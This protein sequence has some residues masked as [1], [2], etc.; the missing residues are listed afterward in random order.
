MMRGAALL[1]CVL[2][3][4]ASVADPLGACGTYHLKGRLIPSKDL[5]ARVVFVVNEGTRS[6]TQFEIP[7][8][9]DLH[10]IGSHLNQPVELVADLKS[11][12]SG[13]RGKI[14][15]IR[16]IHLRAPNPLNDMGYT[17]IR[18]ENCHK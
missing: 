12:I 8:V 16:E 17:R 7:N 3:S 15:D 10:R 2:F 6:E 9:E 4:A 11:P 13:M 5:P 1:I 14:F 18:P